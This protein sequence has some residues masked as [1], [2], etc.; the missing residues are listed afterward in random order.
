MILIQYYRE[1]FKKFLIIQ[2]YYFPD[3]LLREGSVIEQMI[4]IIPEEDWHDQV[5]ILG[6]LYQY[7]NTEPKDNVFAAL[8]KN[9]K[10]TKEN[11]PA[12][13]Q[14]FTPDWIV[15]YMVD[16]SLGRLWNE[17]HP[18]NALEGLEYYISDGEQSENVQKELERGKEDY[19]ELDPRNI[20]CIDPCS[21]SGHVL[22]YM[23]DVLVK[24]YEAYGY[25]AKEAVEFIVDN[26]LWGLDIDDRAAQLAYFSVMM[27]ARQY[28]RRFFTR[29]V[30]PHIYSICDS[31]NID[32]ELINYFA[33]DDSYILEKTNYIVDVLK[34]AKEYGSILQLE[35]IDWSAIDS[36]LNEVANEENI[37]L[38]RYKLVC[39]R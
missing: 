16:N 4:A 39:D 3:Y 6:W 13:T 11:I 30:Q 22:S 32:S 28:D 5:Q 19:K 35:D 12:A 34:N 1:C 25:S 7:Y 9:I 20:R 33:N 21:G 8:K 27:K 29:G 18:G 2:N 31:N 36:R 37:F 24:I 38:I 15:K 17:G 14:I 26:N 10:V 23:F